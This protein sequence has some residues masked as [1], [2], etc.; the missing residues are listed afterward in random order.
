MRNGGNHRLDELDRIWQNTN[1]LTVRA[2]RYCLV[3]FLGPLAI[4]GSRNNL[5]EGDFAAKHTH[6]QAQRNQGG[7][8]ASGYGAVESKYFP[9]I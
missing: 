7:T 5:T 8:F 3:V 2:L 1:Q 4:G 9:Q 6:T